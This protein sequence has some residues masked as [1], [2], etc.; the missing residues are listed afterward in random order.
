MI[1]IDATP[2]IHG[3]HFTLRYDEEKKQTIEILNISHFLRGETTV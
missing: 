2:E 3:H 1:L